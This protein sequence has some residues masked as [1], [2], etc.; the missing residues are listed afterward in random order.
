MLNNREK[1]KILHQMLL[2]MKEHHLTIP[3]DQ[4]TLDDYIKVVYTILKENGI[5]K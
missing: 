2:L 1:T 4:P 3:K 5:M